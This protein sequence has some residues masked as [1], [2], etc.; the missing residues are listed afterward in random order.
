MKRI[1]TLLCA[2]LCTT[3]I[4][5]AAIQTG[6]CGNKVTWSLDTDSG[7]LTISGTGNMS[8]LIK[9]EGISNVYS[10]FPAWKDYSSIIK[11]VII[12]E[13]VTSIRKN[14][15]IGCSNLTSVSIP[16]GITSIGEDAFN[17]CSSLPS[18]KIP[19]SVTS[20]GNN[21]FRN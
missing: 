6:V 17:G 12:S 3:S 5:L 16:E 11:T 1:I 7:V 9:R 8:D 2:I 14:A 21:A 4:A 18:I 13:G 20:I 15:F 10:N 19:E